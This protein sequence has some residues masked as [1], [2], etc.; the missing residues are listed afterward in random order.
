MLETFP[1][2]GLVEMERMGHALKQRLPQVT[3]PTLIVHSEEDDVSSP[4]HARYIA[5]HLGGAKQLHW[6]KD[7]YHMIHVDRQHRQVADLTADFFE[8]H[9]AR[10]SA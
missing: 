7:S 4:R 8:K 5:E 10:N 1:G 2:R 3:T 6:L 9:D